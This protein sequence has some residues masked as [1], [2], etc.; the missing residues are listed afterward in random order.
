[1]LATA[2]GEESFTDANG[3]GTF[4]GAPDTFMDLGERFRDDNESGAYE[5]GE[6][7]LDFNLSA[8]HDSQTPPL[9]GAPLFNGLLCQPAPGSGECATSVVTGI[10]NSGIIIMSGSVATITD[11]V[12]GALAAPGTVTF[13]VGDVNSQPMPAGTTIKFEANNGKIIGPSDYVVPCTSFDGPLDFSFFVDGDG[14][15]STAAGVLTVE[16]PGPGVGG[17]TG[18]ISAPYFISITD[19]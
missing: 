1:V 17:A 18:I 10:G 15:G 13:T 2:I 3:N 7:F 5:V 12:L 19:L 16:T 6:F 4:D 9:P 8:A 14:M 11:N